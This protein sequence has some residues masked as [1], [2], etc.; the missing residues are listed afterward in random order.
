MIGTK[1]LF[2]QAVFP[3]FGQMQAALK[4]RGRMPLT[5][6]VLLR[7]PAVPM[8]RAAAAAGAARRARAASR[9]EREA[10]RLKSAGQ[11]PLD[12]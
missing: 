6:A 9:T 3:L 2:V 11:G 12:A 7:G 10:A 1:Q 5:A 4:D 8:P